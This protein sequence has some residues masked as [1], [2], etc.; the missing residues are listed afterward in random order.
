MIRPPIT[1]AEQPPRA[2]GIGAF[3]LHVLAT[4]S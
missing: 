2:R 1:P 3:V 4:G